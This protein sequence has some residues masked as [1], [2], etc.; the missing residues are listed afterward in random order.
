MGKPMKQTNVVLGVTALL[1]LVG[2]SSISDKAKLEYKTKAVQMPPLE[3][4]PKLSVPEMEQRY[5]IPEGEAGGVASYSEYTKQK[6]EQPCVAPVIASAP[7]AAAPAP[8]APVPVSAPASVVPPPKLQ[9]N[10]GVKR[11][12]LGEPFD[13]SWRRVGLALDQSRVSVIDKDRSLGIYYVAALKKADK[14]RSYSHL[15]TVR[16]NQ[17]GCEVTVTDPNGKSGTVSARV[18]DSIYQGLNSEQPSGENTPPSG[19]G[20]LP[21]AP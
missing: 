8:A 18:I 2:C 21:P 9:D 7:V 12:L 14:I 19:S 11:I 17:G 20:N 5:V 1:L 3:V 6:P 4:P 10:N 15:V 16:E 13:R